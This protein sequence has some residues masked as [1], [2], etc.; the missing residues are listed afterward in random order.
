MVGLKNDHV[1][2]TNSSFGV[3][4]STSLKKLEFLQA[5]K[6]KRFEYKKNV[7][8]DSVSNL[9]ADLHVELLFIFHKV[10]IRLL[11]LRRTRAEKSKWH[12]LTWNVESEDLTTLVL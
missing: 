11:D 2:A 8:T 5:I 7:E 12:C 10:C 3:K 4:T 6:E 9:I 1:D